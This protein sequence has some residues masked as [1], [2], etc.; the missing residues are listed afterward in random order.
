MTDEELPPLL[1]AFFL[2]A[3]EAFAVGFRQFGVAGP[4]LPL[5]EELVSRGLL[6]PVVSPSGRR[7]F[8]LSDAGRALSPK[9]PAPRKNPR[10]EANKTEPL[11][12][13]PPEHLHIERDRW[14]EGGQHCVAPTGLT[15]EHLPTGIRVHVDLGHSL[16]QHAL[17]ALAIDAIL[18]ALTS[19]H[20]PAHLLPR[21]TS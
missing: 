8:A 12:M 19:P 4:E 20:F 3:K 16:P 13:I 5:A 14:P 7:G 18:G 15:V 6:L 17:R 21:S 11:G 9:A 2:N 10:P 1:R